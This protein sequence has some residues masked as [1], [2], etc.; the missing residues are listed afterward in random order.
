MLLGSYG[1]LSNAGGDP[2]TL[3]LQGL[4]SEIVCMAAINYNEARQAY[5]AFALVPG[6]E[7]LKFSLIGVHC[8]A[9]AN[10]R[11]LVLILLRTLF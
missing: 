2:S 3:T 1:R 7:G 11:P 10:S 6:Y 9:F 5:S 8:F 4:A